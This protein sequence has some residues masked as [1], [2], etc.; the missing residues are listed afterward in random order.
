M[1]VVSIL[2]HAE[3][4]LIDHQEDAPHFSIVFTLNKSI[5]NLTSSSRFP[6]SMNVDLNEITMNLVPFP[7]MHYLTT[8]LAPLYLS[9]DLHLPP[10]RLDEMFTDAFSGQNALIGAD[11]RHHVFTASGLIAR[12]KIDITDMRRNVVR[13]TSS[14]NFVNWNKE[15]WKVGLCDVPPGGQPFSLLGLHNTT[16]VSESF[17]QLRNRFVKLYKRKGNCIIKFFL[18]YAGYDF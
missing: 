12:G 16:A 3:F 2:P 13:M 11:P 17:V 10:R 9:K 1:V 18:R 8:C 15:G 6:G 4:G 7:R 5:L 14:L